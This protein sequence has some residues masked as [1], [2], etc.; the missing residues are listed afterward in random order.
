[1][2]H[3]ESAVAWEPH[4]S[5]EAMSNV[6]ISRLCCAVHTARSTIK[7]LR[8]TYQIERYSKWRETLDFEALYFDLV[9]SY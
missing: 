2:I 3:A 7:N 5:Q 4:K 6:P 9:I 8:V 1:M